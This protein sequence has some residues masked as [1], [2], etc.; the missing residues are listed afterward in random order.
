M[1]HTATDVMDHID[2]S[3]QPTY[4]VPKRTPMPL[5]DEVGKRILAA[6]DGFWYERKTPWMHL[7]T[8]IAQQASV[9]LPYGDLTKYV[10]FDFKEFPS[11]LL[12]I[13]ERTLRGKMNHQTLLAWITW[14]KKCGFEYNDVTHRPG[15]PNDNSYQQ[16]VE[17]DSRWLV[18]ELQFGEN[19]QAS[20]HS[21]LQHHSG[22]GYFVA[23]YYR[24][25]DGEMKKQMNLHVEDMRFPIDDVIMQMA[26]QAGA[27]RAS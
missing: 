23:K 15:P 13:F 6:S 17:E 11:D 26:Q 27:G 7:R 3:V 24:G 10:S 8:K 18:L 1:E 19:V 21:L 16:I 9:H 4:M 20:P 25:V 14:S 12:E 5:L 22:G 2:Q